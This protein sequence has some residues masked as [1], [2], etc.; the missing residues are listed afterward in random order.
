MKNFLFL[1]ALVAVATAQ[2]VQSQTLAALQSQFSAPPPCGQACFANTPH[3]TG[4]VGLGCFGSSDCLCNQ[5]E[6]RF[7]IRD[8]C[9]SSCP[10]PINIAE[11][12]S[13]ITSWCAA[14]GG[15]D[16]S[17]IFSANI[18]LTAPGNPFSTASAL[19]TTPPPSGG[20]PPLGTATPLTV[21]S[22]TSITILPT[23]REPDTRRRTVRWP[24]NKATFS[25]AVQ[26]SATDPGPTV[27][28]AEEVGVRERENLR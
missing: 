25:T 21:T 6:F 7:G 18:A 9:D 13:Y 14:P 15:V 22:I 4:T 12:D 20:A 19:I 2:S 10:S 11:V 17:N 16:P 3:A 24:P 8:C 5:P 28:Y 1:A 27:A 23:G 26:N